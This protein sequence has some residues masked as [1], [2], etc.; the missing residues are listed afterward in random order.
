[1]FHKYQ[2][3]D[4]T[5]VNKKAKYASSYNFQDLIVG[6]LEFLKCY[7]FQSFMYVYIYLF[8]MV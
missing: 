2:H 3:R 5:L 8:M 7:F 6:L 1:L 4:W